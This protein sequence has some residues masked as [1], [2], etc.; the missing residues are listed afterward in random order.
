MNKTIIIN[1]NGLVFHIEEDAYEVLRTYMTEVKR[2]FA[3]SPDSNEIVTDIE[4]R[5][6]EMFSERLAAENKQVIV[7]ADVIS[8]T[9]IMGNVN[10]FDIDD[11]DDDASS[12][13]G[14]KLYRDLDERIL[15]GVCAGMAHYFSIEPRWMR[16]LAIL[17]IF[18]GGI[19][20][21]V[22]IIL[23]IIMPAAKTRADKMAMKG[24]PIN[25]QNFKRNFDEE[26]EGLKGGFHRAHSEVRPAIFQ[27]GK[28]I[29]TIAKL[30]VKFIVAIVAFFGIL[31][32]IVLFIGLITFLGYWN[33]NELNTFP[34]TI[35][36]PGYK[37]V[38][39]FSAFIIVFIPIAAL[40]MFAL[41]ILVKRIAIS[42]TVYFTMLIIWIGGLIMGAYHGSKIASE[43]NEEAEFSVT[44]PLNPSPVYYLR[45]NAVEF[46]TKEDSVRYKIDPT[47]FKGTVITRDRDFNNPRSVRIQILKGD[48][49][50]PTLIQEFSAR[51]SNFEEALGTARRVNHG[52]TQQDSIITFDPKTH[53][54]RGELWRDQSVRLI[55]RIPENTRVMIEA[56]VNRYLNDH[57]YWDC[58]PEDA[59]WDYIS[60][61]KMT[62]EGLK[63]QYVKPIE[64][65]V[66]ST[67]VEVR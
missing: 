52:F 40:V 37:S 2:H 54:Q 47:N 32:M 18:F 55:L 57:D 66:D 62:A 36:N 4:N 12:K 14:R 53:L 65:D 15:G 29:E 60:A 59:Q 41:R 3:Y 8:V 27:I 67:S 35:V 48:V 7:L 5:L 46:L 20:L 21:P 1:I 49:N 64:A 33:S 19:G 9:A 22:Y 24:E 13:S 23:W 26:V 51:G 17:F 25:L 10:D 42:K 16:L 6:A 30:F 56:P 63:C 39:A 44:T 61:W 11:E 45:V 34:F 38:L 43:F 28:F 31:A 58:R 50:K